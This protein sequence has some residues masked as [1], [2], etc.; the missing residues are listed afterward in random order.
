MRCIARIF[1][2]FSFLFFFLSSFSYPSNCWFLACSLA[3]RFSRTF[4]GDQARHRTDGVFLSRDYRVEINPNTSRIRSLQRELES[5][6]ATDRLFH[7]SKRTTPRVRTYVRTYRSIRSRI[8]VLRQCQLVRP[9]PSTGTTGPSSFEFTQL[10][11]SPRSFLRAT[12]R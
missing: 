6:S 7:R 1:S 3:A 2:L 11:L 10:L 4:N 12:C 5:C 8:L 9:F